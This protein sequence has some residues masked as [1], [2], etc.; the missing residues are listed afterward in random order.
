LVKRAS[1]NIKLKENW[2]KI[3]FDVMLR[4]LNKKFTQEPFKSKLIETGD[5]FIMEGNWWNDT[6]WGVCLKTNTGHNYLGKL[7]MSIRTE[8]ITG[9]L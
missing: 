7:I 9:K 3:K 6:Y 4:C 2:D 8:I 1:R 5:A